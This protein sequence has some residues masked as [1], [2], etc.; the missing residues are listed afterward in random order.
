MPGHPELSRPV[1]PTHIL[2]G[3]VCDTL[4]LPGLLHQLWWREG[5]PKGNALSLCFRAGVWLGTLSGSLL[6][7]RLLD[8]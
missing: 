8:L 1:S 2:P 3:T 6:F 5:L 7:P 4:S